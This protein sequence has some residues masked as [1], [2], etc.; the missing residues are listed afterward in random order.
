MSY[1]LRRRLLLNKIM[2][3]TPFIKVYPIEEMWI[4]V[5]N[6]ITFEVKSNTKW[7]I[8]SEE[9]SINSVK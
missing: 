4:D 6:I 5:G 2:N 3:E 1:K 8:D 7:N 9:E